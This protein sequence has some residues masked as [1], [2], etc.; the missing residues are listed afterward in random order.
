M[1]LTEPENH[2]YCYYYYISS[3]TKGIT[4]YHLDC[5]HFNLPISNLNLV[6][7]MKILRLGKKTQE[8]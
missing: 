3:T 7:K 8:K 2:K 4:K 6:G 1:E 5:W